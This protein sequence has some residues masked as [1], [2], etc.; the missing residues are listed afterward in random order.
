MSRVRI[1]LIGWLPAYAVL[2]VLF[3]YGPVLLLPL[4]SLN[5]AA[6]PTLP[7]AGWTFKWYAQLAGNREMINAAWNSLQVGAAAALLSTI[8]GICGARAIT[9][10]QFVGKRPMSA[11][12]MAP[13]VLPE[14]IVA[15]S[16]LLVMLALGL[17]LSLVTVTLGHVLICLPYSM[18][19]LIS[20]FEGFD[21]SLEEAST[22]LGETAPGTF[23]RVTLPLVAPAISASLLVSFTIS[24][25]EFI[26]AFFLSGSDPTLPIYIWGQ[27]R[28]ASRLPSVLALGTI[29]LIGSFVLITIAELLRRRAVRRTRIE[30][31]PHG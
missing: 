17:S 13:L 18:V 12:I 21:R 28:F 11:L 22:D 6:T 5:D 14:I 1:A 7:L 10:Y 31:I 24:F 30:G 4:F 29:M 26:V 19:V 20:G 9:R 23:R 27:L 2:Y 25:D 15:I 3:L 8:L 16:L